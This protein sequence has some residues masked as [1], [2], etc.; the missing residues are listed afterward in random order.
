MNDR[1]RAPTPE[2]LTV[3]VG[4]VVVALFLIASANSERQ[5][6]RARVLVHVNQAIKAK[7]LLSQLWLEEAV[8]G[9]TTIDIPVDVYGNIDEARRLAR[10]MLVGGSKS[11]MKVPRLEAGHA[12]E[13][14][15]YIYTALGSWRSDAEAR[16]VNVQ[17][18]AIGSDADQAYDETGQDILRRL[19]ESERHIDEEAAKDA[20]AL[21]SSKWATGGV[22]G[23]L[24]LALSALLRRHR[25]ALDANN[26][27]LARLAAIV[28][29]SDDAILSATLD[30]VIV[31]SNPAA[32]KLSGHPAGEL[33]GKSVP[34]LLPA[35]P[36]G[37]AEE[38]LARIGRGESIESAESVLIR[39]DGSHVPVSVTT[40]PIRNTAGDVVAVSTIARD[41][42][43]RKQQ[44]AALAEAR[45]QAL[46]TSRLKSEFLAVMSHE[47][48]TPMNGVIGLTGLLLDTPLDPRQREYAE[49]VRAAGEALLAVINDILDFSKIEAGKLELETVDFDLVQAVDDVTG[50]VAASAWEK[51]LEL[52]GYCQPDVPTALRGDVGRIRQILLN[53]AS[54]AV[55]FTEHGEVVVRAR[56]AEEAGPDEVTVRFE[57]SDTG[58][59]IGRGALDR[60]FEAFSQADASTTRRFGG[61]GLGLAISRRLV[62][63]MG[64][65]IG[66]ES[67]IGKGSL[68]W[69]TLPLARQ[70][71]G[72]APPTD[73]THRLHGMRV[74]IVDDNHTNRVAL[75]SQLSSWDM[76]AD[77]VTDADSALRRLR[78]A[79]D[80]AQPYELVLLDMLMPGMDG[81]DLARRIR[82]DPALGSPRMVLLSSSS[83][84]DGRETA[85]AGIAA[86]LTKPVRHSQL[87][88]VLARVMAPA[89]EQARG[90]TASP[91]PT[92]TRAPSRGHVLLVED[93]RTNQMVARAMLDRLGCDVDVVANGFEAV[94]AVQRRRYTAVF[95]DC[96][97]PEMDGFEATAE[98]RRRERHSDGRVP[99]I[100]LTASALLEDRERALAAGMDDFLPKPIKHHELDDM[101]NRWVSRA[102]T[103][104][105]ARTAGSPAGASPQGVL[106]ME[107]F[108]SLREVAEGSGHPTF[109]RDLVDRFLEG[110]ESRMTEL[111]EAARRGDAAAF[112]EAA[113]ALRGASA[114]MSATALASV[115]ATLESAACRGKVGGREDLDRV[116]AELARAEAALRACVP[117]ARTG[118]QRE[119][120]RRQGPAANEGQRG[121]W[122]K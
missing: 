22:T 14:L 65:T 21:R 41:I 3:A 54:N 90:E 105:P 32:E 30:G 51:D 10:T 48:R 7:V 84:I 57:V 66:V 46:E 31:S 39:K 19:D 78:H 98:I 28:Q 70:P 37:E 95:M 117:G 6:N 8:A 5:L 71:H 27:E 96:H 59:G 106:D 83:E 60:L 34:T 100:A 81:L 109:L 16:M 114:T 67:E 97:M 101:L 73:R 110:A 113:H 68:F 58:I 47:I 80:R 55:K 62:E 72:Q 4:A 45:D 111:Q 87:Y 91:A 104:E 82:A 17:T 49:G 122:G 23:L 99:I 69:F 76:R 38:M 53:L 35:E 64:G 102:A 29:S 115:C 119:D 108:A 25:H 116:S 20:A 74:L 56:L 85:D 112:E 61:S 79:A 36:P 13:D 26:A 103:P 63:A 42:T 75:E 24:F 18:G 33:V 50:L 11:T 44:E 92:A 118:P 86:R 120:G 40:S 52:V 94:D 43:A 2:I 88:D 12:R 77:A 1:H 15:E 9:D 93:N 107:Q 89:P 121:E